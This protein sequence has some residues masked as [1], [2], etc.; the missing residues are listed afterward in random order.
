MLTAF[1]LTQVACVF[2]PEDFEY[3]YATWCDTA[4]S[5][6]VDCVYDGDTFYLGGCG[7]D[8]EEDFRLLGIQAPELSTDSD[9]EPQCYGT[10]A[11]ELLEEL[12]LGERVRLEF[13]VECQGVFGR[14][15]AWVFLEDPSPAV[16]STIDQIEGFDEEIDTTDTT[17]DDS[18]D[19]D[20]ILINEVMV[21]A[22]YATLY[23]GEVANN[24]RYSSRLEDALEQAEDQ[25]RGLWGE[26]D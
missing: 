17:A 7:A 2:P 1:L 22:G 25:S 18:E 11:T 12:V 13:D 16:I 19:L 24:V 21:R 9:E 4:R 15:L 6:V 3:A 23:E 14:T 20:E 5:E 10:E 26:C 8:S